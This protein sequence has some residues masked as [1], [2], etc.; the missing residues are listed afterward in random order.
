LLSFSSGLLLGMVV[1]LLLLISLATYG[2]QL[3]RP[4]FHSLLFFNTRIEEFIE[5]PPGMIAVAP[6]SK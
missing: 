1:V 5:T 6:T 2:S 4:C 3:G